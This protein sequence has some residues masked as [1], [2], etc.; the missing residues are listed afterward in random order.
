MSTLPLHVLYNST[1][2]STLGATYFSYMIVT[3]DFLDG[4]NYTSPDM[5]SYTGYTRFEEYRTPSPQQFLAKYNDGN[6]TKLTPAQCIAA[7]SSNYI[8][9]YGH[10]LAVSNSSSAST[11][12]S[13]GC[14]FAPH[15]SVNITDY[16]GVE[17]MPYRTGPQLSSAIRSLTI[18]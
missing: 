14:A 2:F 9:G 11:R 10:L 3:P 8:S 15:W 1:V 5:A 4:A 17:R 7:Y 13:L 16:Y 6:L 18:A 12:L